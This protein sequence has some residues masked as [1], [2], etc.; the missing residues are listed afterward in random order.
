MEIVI[1]Y[2]VQIF[3]DKGGRRPFHYWFYNLRDEKIQA[4]IINRI[5]RLSLGNLGDCKKIGKLYELRINF[6]PGYRIYFGMEN[7][8][9]ITLLLGGTKRSQNRD[10]LKANIFWKEYG[11]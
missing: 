1:P 2:T 11:E 9:I 4:V 5:N 8:R 3:I 10:I 7:Q 6:G